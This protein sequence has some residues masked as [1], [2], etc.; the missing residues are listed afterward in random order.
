MMMS[1]SRKKHEMN[2]TTEIYHQQPFGC[3]KLEDG[4]FSM[5]FCITV[6]YI[7]GL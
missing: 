7:V 5:Y 1:D 6:A 4:I 2:M 3:S